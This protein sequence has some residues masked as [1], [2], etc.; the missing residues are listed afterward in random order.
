MQFNGGWG[1]FVVIARVRLMIRRLSVF[2]VASHP[3]RETSIVRIAEI[4]L[5]RI[6]PFALN[7]ES[8]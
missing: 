4:K 2:T 6:V 8:S 1:C 3:L 5:T 7:A